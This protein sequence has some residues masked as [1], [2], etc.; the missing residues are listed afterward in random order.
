MK[1]QSNLSKI[2]ENRSKQTKII[3]IITRIES[4]QLEVMISDNKKG[5]CKVKNISDF[6]NGKLEYF[7]NVGDKHYFSKITTDENNGVI[8]LD[9]KGIHPEEIKNKIKLI[10]TVSSYQTLKQKLQIWINGYY[11]DTKRK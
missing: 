8:L 1:N 9:Y 5:I 3:G 11:N 4:K 2:K 6:V 10:N 7:F